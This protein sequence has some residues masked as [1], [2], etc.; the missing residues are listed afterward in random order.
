MRPLKIGIAG[1]SIGG[2]TAA[3]LLHELGHDVHVFERSTAALEGRGAGIVVLPVT[4]RYFTE[5]DA[6]LGRPGGP[7]EVALTLTYWSYVDASGQ[8]I[9]AAPTHNRFTSWNT[10]YRALLSAF[11]SDRYH[12]SHEVVGFEQSEDGVTMSFVDGSRHDCELMVAA[13]GIASTA[14]RILSP[15]TTTDYV[16]YVAWRGTVTESDVSA[17]TAS[18]IADTMVYQVLDHSHLLVYAIPGPGDS[19]VPG[20]RDVNFVWYRNY[21]EGEFAELMTDRHGVHR[22]AT[23]PPGLARTR[24]VDELRAEAREVLAPPLRELV[25]ACDEPFVQAI[26]D[27]MAD[28]FRHGRVILIGDAAAAVRPHVAA[29]QA[30]ACADGWALRDHLARHDDLDT[31]L[32]GWET[33]Q[34][35]VARRTVARS[36][37]MGEA[38]QVTGTMVPGDPAWRFGLHGPGEQV[39]NYSS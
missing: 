16:G 6:G 7:R 3:V 35:E 27:M 37:E 5:R 34:L 33:Q 32:A 9:D 30:K 13:D 31:A 39:A 15:D 18:V 10:L 20:E 11:P 38:S 17:E 24:F 23:M 1:G 26:F 25:L 22:P 12:L 14:R 36:R 19:I 4:E 29:G 28:R 2:L 21:G 8:V